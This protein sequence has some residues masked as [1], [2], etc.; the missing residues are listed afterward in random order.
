M[1]QPLASM[2]GY[3]RSNG[4]VHGAS[5]ACEVKTVNGRGLDIRLRLAPGFDTLESDIRQ[6]IG[7]TL[8]RGSVTL[9][10][11]V[12]R[13]GAGGELYINRQ[14]LD[15]VLA[16]LDELKGRVE[17]A[18]PS[19]DGIL[20]LRGVLEQRDSVLD[21]DGEALRAAI[22][23]A[24]S[25]ALIDLTVARRQE[26]S[27]MSVVLLDRL[28]EIEALVARAEAH[29]ARSREVILALLRQQVADLATD[30]KLSEDRLAQEALLLATKADIRE[31]LDRLTAHI[32]AAREL[33][34]TGGAAGR[35]LDFL[36][37]EFNREA[38]TLCS[39][40]NAVELTAIGLD[41]KAAIDQLREQVQN[42]E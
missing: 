2:T 1:S 9:N 30:I 13:Q 35:R 16:A 6:L 36:A 15:T 27:R 39:K 20:A 14:A 7:T 28:L 32:A 34:A 40:S 19:L 4:A 26:G 42:I 41:L 11:T 33:I 22:L 18:P 25:T 17:A 37:Q 5:F 10:L 8:T 24:V 3:A 23:D 31:E 38:N 21:E 29:P 12:E